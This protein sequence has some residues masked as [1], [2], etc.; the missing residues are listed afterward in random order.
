MVR[1]VK[2]KK[3]TL[4]GTLLIC[5]FP[6]TC[7]AFFSSWAPVSFYQGKASSYI[8][9]AWC[10]NGCSTVLVYT[11]VGQ[12]L[13]QVWKLGSDMNIGTIRMSFKSR[14]SCVVESKAS[15]VSFPC[16]YSSS[17]FKSRINSSRSWEDNIVSHSHSCLSSFNN[18]YSVHLLGIYFPYPLYHSILMHFIDEKTES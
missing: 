9:S 2:S 3:G 11:S 4:S 14:P 6:F 18:H 7:T 15:Y 16:C 5:A 10:R 1:G 8:L 13:D 17:R 12:G